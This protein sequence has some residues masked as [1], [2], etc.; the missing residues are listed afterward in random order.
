VAPSVLLIDDAA[1]TRQALADLLRKR[2]YVVHEA[3]NGV[4]GLDVLRQHPEVCVTVLDLL[5]PRAD[6][7]SFR[8]AQLADPAIAHV[9]VIVFTVA[10]KTE[11]LKYTL[12]V[13]EVLHKPA[14]VDDLLAAID[15][16]C[17]PAR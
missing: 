8:E 9:P 5:M 14:S 15:R 17:A 1:A 13:Q 2:G 11:I 3:G 4:D 6:G 10:G 7:W 16:C 12:K